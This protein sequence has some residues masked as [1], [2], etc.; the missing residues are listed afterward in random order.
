MLLLNNISLDGNP[1]LFLYFYIK[2]VAEMVFQKYTT[3]E[4]HC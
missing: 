4:I 3:S 2:K 1:L